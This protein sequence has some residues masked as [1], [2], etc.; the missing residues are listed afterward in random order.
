MERLAFRVLVGAE[1]DDT[2]KCSDS[3][4]TFLPLP[5]VNR[6]SFVGTEEG[7]L[8]YEVNIPGRMAFP[9]ITFA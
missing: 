7:I 9:G 8:K 5:L 1:M 4:F 3:C 2:C 6:R